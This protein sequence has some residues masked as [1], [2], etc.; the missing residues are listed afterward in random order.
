[1]NGLGVGLA[2][3]QVEDGALISSATRASL[4]L[5]SGKGGNAGRVGL[6]VLQNSCRVLL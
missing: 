3:I 6:L 2:D 4:P 5:P 1:M